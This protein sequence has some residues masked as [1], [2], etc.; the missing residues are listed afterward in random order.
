MENRGELSRS[1]NLWHVVIL[2]LAYMTPMV[3]FDTFGV[4][5]E[6]TD[7]HVPAAYL[8]A[9]A[10][11]LFTASSYGKMVKIY[12]TAGSAYTYT[13]K[14]MN[15]HLG[16]MVGWS[17]LLA[18][19][20]LPMINALLLKIYCSALFPEVPSWV[21]IVSLVVLMTAVN[22]MGATISAN[23]NSLLI[24]FQC[25]VLV[26]FVALT[27]RGLVLGEG[28]GTIISIQPFMSSEVNFSALISGATILCFS[29]IGFDAI[30]TLTEETKDP[31]KTIPRGIFLVALL[32]GLMFISV[33][34]FTQ[35][36]FPDNSRFT[37]PT[38]AGPEMALYIGGQLFQSVFMA[39][40]IIGVI[41]S[42]I[43]SHASVSRLLYVM[44]RDKVLPAKW[45]GYIEVRRAT[46]V[47]NIILVGV[48]ALI[49][50]FLDLVTAVSFINF[51]ALIAFT[52][53][54]LSVIAHYGFREKKHKTAKGFLSYVVS[55]LMGTSFVGVL[56]MNLEVKSLIFGISWAVIGFCYLLYL[57]KFFTVK[58]PEFHFEEASEIMVRENAS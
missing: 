47:Y 39:G 45:F 21:W 41:A 43:S 7:G 52:F 8:L 13:Q 29:F 5:S 48:V 31:K 54:N 30:T 55:P 32:G 23:L 9:L 53:V 25:L 37:D 33:S 38:A 34:Y 6:I 18:Y 22:L 10:A 35:S 24:V 15:K 27:I 20:F 28:T 49:A 46:P 17:S 16:F 57:T 2:G 58:P 44:G 40:I 19:L 14:S 12:P 26:L 4:V 51:G 50:L 42:G 36:Y 11:M 3:V 56:W 1:L